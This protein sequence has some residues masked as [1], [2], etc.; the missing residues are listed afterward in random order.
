MRLELGLKLLRPLGARADALS[1]FHDLLHEIVVGIGQLFPIRLVA[2]GLSQAGIIDELTDGLGGASHV[3][4]ADVEAALAEHRHPSDLFEAGE[5]EAKR[6]A[7]ERLKQAP[8]E[9]A[10]DEDHTQPAREGDHDEGKEERSDKELVRGGDQARRMQEWM[11]V[12]HRA[13][14]LSETKS[15]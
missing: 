1:Q 7:L 14:S 4:P 5:G 6:N 13:R 3:A 8:A 12:S 2:N 15:G 9:R 11:G 10:P